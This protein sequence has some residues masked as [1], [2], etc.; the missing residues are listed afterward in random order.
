[1]IFFNIQ[2][3]LGAEKYL[4]R[5]IACIL[6]IIL[7]R[8]TTY[9]LATYIKKIFDRTSTNSDSRYK[10]SKVNFSIFQTI[11]FFSLLFIQSLFAASSRG[12]K[13]VSKAFLLFS[14]AVALC[15][16]TTPVNRF[17]R[18]TR[19]L[20]LSFLSFSLFYFFLS[21]ILISFDSYFSSFNEKKKNFFV[22][23]FILWN[24]SATK[25][26]REGWI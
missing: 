19:S 6:P 10:N 9:E 26:N 3:I 8:T 22:N 15:H 11:V 2:P 20:G 18:F 7:R 17:I 14:S 23:K 21:N 24:D 4:S 13:Y 1:M 25:G 5:E 16:P 12:S